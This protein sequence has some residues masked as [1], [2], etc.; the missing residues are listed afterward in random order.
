[1]CFIGF[2]NPTGLGFNQEGRLFAAIN[3]ADKRASRPIV[4][5]S[6]KFY[7]RKLNGISFYGWPEF[8]GTAQPVTDPK[9][10]SSKDNNGQQLE[11]LMQHHPP[12]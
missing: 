4:S 3:G 2:R 12:C 10:Q 8:F 7:E 1:L 6:D 5:D 11:F 9:F